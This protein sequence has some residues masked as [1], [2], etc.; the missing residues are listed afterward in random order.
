MAAIGWHGARYGSW[1]VDDAA[2]TFA[3]ARSFADGLGPVVAP[4]APPVE[5]FSN[6]TWTALLALGKVLGLFDRGTLFGVP[7]YVLFPKALAML[8][9]VGIL[10]ACHQAAKK[11]ARHPSLVTLATGLVLAAIPSFVIWCFSCLENSLYACVVMWLA[12]VLFRAS[13]DGRLLTAKVAATVGLLAAAA[14][15][16]RP[17]GM[18]YAAAYPVLLAV[19]LRHDTLRVSVHKGLFSTI[20]FGLPFGAYLIWR[21]LEFGQWVANTVV[22]KAQG[23][24]DVTAPLRVGDLVTYAGALTV[25]LSAV[26]VARMSAKP[27][28]VALLVPFALAVTAYIVLP[29]DWM[30]ELRFATPVWTLG[31]LIGALA[32]AK[33]YER[34]RVRGRVVL[35]AALVAVLIPSGSAFAGAAERFRAE[36]TFPMC[37]VA[38]RIGRTFNEYA[39]LLGLGRASLL[40]PDLGGSAMTSRLALVDMA[41]LAD[42]KIARFTR[43]ANWGPMRDYLF[44]EVKPTFVHLRIFW[45]AAT[46]IE[47]DPR[48]ARDYLPIHRYPAGQPGGDFVRKDAVRTPERLQAVRAY[49][50]ETVPE[51]EGKLAQWPRR[52]CGATLRP[53]QTAV[54]ET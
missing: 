11:V 38:D 15:L 28:L 2:I 25:L 51:V 10:V 24:P 27:G 47:T 8:C 52:H 7:D 23:L 20:A 1:L 29:G 9:C 50:A 44:D 33:A 19:K 5:G 32:A 22:V 36:P 48:L 54:G 6:P 34:F 46:G 14:A 40:A 41:G 31:T 13:L 4:G 42:T 35:S 39:D 17:D 26:L 21:R 12:V 43:D 37:F 16:T 30:G 53:G 45:G 18:I 49:A 3:Y